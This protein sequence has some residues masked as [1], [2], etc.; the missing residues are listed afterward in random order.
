M[1]HELEFYTSENCEDPNTKLRG[2]PI[3]MQGPKNVEAQCSLCISMSAFVLVFDDT[4]YIYRYHHCLFRPYN[5]VLLLA[6]KMLFGLGLIAT[7]C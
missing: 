7:R 6:K 3:A 2:T 4:K 5:E 1:V